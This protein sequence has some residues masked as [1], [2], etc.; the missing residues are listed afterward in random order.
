M[1]DSLE[2]I[3][4]LFPNLEIIEL[5]GCGGMGSVYKARQPSLERLVALKVIRPRIVQSPEFVERFKREAKNLESLSASIEI[6]G[7]G[8]AVISVSESLGASISGAGD[9]SYYG[10]PKLTSKISGHG[11]ITKL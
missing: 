8:D 7:G 4:E 2:E 3:R 11:K 1:F 10:N 6:S 9:I 5:L